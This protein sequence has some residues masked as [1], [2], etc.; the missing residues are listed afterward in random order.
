MGRVALHSA[1]ASGHAEV[2]RILLDAKRAAPWA[3]GG[4]GRTGTGSAADDDSK[5]GTVESVDTSSWPSSSWPALAPAPARA[6]PLR[7]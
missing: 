6:P 2:V 5:L 3:T 7:P 4:P 1:A